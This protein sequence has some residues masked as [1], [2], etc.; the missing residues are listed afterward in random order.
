MECGDTFKQLSARHL[1]IH[2]LDP[3]SYRT[4]YGIPPTQSLSSRDATARR[5]AVAQQVR[6]WEGAALKRSAEQAGA[7][8]RGGKP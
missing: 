8:K 5:R 3:R 7:K 6:P 4:K 2:D 1:R